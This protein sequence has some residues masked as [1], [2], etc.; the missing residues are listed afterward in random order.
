M[1]EEKKLTTEQITE[2]IADWLN[3]GHMPPKYGMPVMQPVM[4]PIRYTPP[5]L[6]A[7]NLSVNKLLFPMCKVCGGPLQANHLCGNHKEEKKS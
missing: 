5:P 7:P 1:S 6:G 3:N 4:Q 2:A